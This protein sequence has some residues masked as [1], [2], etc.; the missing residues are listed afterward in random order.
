M[1]PPSSSSTFLVRVACDFGS[2]KVNTGFEF[3][4]KPMELSE[5]MAVVEAFYTAELRLSSGLETTVF[6]CVAC[7][8]LVDVLNEG[9]DRR[10]RW[11]EV[12]RMDQIAH[13]AQLYVFDANSPPPTRG[14]I[15][16]VQVVVTRDQVLQSASRRSH[17]HSP[18]TMMVNHQSPSGGGRNGGGGVFTGALTLPS[19]TGPSPPSSVDD[20]ALQQLFTSLR[21][22]PLRKSGG[23]DSNSSS[24]SS[25][26][27]CAVLHHALSEVGLALP[28]DVFVE[29]VE[30]RGS[31]SH[32]DWQ[33]LVAEYR[34]LF[35]LLYV[36]LAARSGQQA[37]ESSLHSASER[38]R[39][40]Q[41]EEHRLLIRHAELKRDIAA[42]A[43]DVQEESERVKQQDSGSRQ[44]AT[45]TAT[46]QK[47]V[48][49]KIR[50]S[51][52]RREEAQI[53]RELKLCEH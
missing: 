51:K 3:P 46:V 18:M 13:D 47:F 29:V 14:V 10:G 50:Q 53:E 34:P 9:G 22:R 49:L 52:L 43:R 38:L 24:S 5:L 2:G 4:S 40:L 19:A 39:L 12:Q 45:E 15:P 25:S 20:Q 6:Q 21:S 30:G 17:S 36:R 31:L 8:C 27:S 35:E 11:V 44:D 48:T 1:P 41:A 33:A 7:L 26:L 32:R 28:P 16:R 37:A 23:V 42:A